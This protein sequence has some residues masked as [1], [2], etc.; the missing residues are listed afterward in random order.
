MTDVGSRAGRHDTSFSDKTR[1][2]L[3]D[4]AM[5]ATI[6]LVRTS[7]WARTR[8][9]DIAART[10]ISKPTLYKYFGTKDQLA[11]AYVDAEVDRIFQLGL[12]AR[13]RNPDDPEVALREATA[14]ILSSLSESPLI[15]AILANNDAS[16]TVLPLV[17]QHGPRLLRRAT[18][19]L[20]E[21]VDEVYVG[22]D[23][24]DLRAYVDMY[25]RATISHAIMP[26]GSFDDSVDTIMR[27]VLPVLR[28]FEQRSA[29]APDDDAPSAPDTRE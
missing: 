14:T 25:L 6:E 8:M 19:E 4:V 2:L 10:G 12:E 26:T 20:S 5:Q 17:T 1:A 7:G 15:L 24:A 22:I 29:V 11:H 13:D 27:L 28:R 3:H 16:A 23:P 18:D 9:S 21:L